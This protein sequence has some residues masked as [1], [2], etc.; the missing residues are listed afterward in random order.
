MIAAELGL[1][2]ARSV[3]IGD[4][5]TDVQLADAVGAVGL[6]VKTGYGATQA[7]A[8]PPDVSATAVTDHLIDAVGW[9]LRE[10]VPPAGV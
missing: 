5:W 3:V 9:V 2:L 10:L 4:R 8:Q 7:A 6:L 1:D